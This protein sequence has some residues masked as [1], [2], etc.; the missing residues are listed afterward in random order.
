MIVHGLFWKETSTDLAFLGVYST[1]L[2]A[3]E[4]WQEWA[5]SRDYIAT[6]ESFV[7]A[8]ELDDKAEIVTLD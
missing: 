4:A 3:M 7:L 1:P 5:R 2:K 6:N 8:M